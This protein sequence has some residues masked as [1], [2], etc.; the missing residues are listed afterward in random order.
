[1]CETKIDQKTLDKLNI[2][3]YLPDY[4]GYFEWCKPPHKGYSG[5]GILTKVEPLTISYGITNYGK[6]KHRIFLMALWKYF[7]MQIHV[8][9]FLHVVCPIDGFKITNLMHDAEGR[10]ITL[11]FDT[12]YLVSVYVPNSQELLRRLEYRI[13]EWDIDFRRYWKSLLKTGKNVLIVGDMNVAHYPIDL[14]CPRQSEWMAGFSYYE[15][16]SFTQLLREGF[17]DSFRELH[18]DKVQYTWWSNRSKRMRSWNLGWRLDYA[19]PDD[20]LMLAVEDSE[21]HDFARISDHCPVM[22]KLD[23]KRMYDVYNAQKLNQK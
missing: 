17:N 22:I 10:V 2:S 9:Q 1:M 15:R 5:V 19:I 12:F 8:L 7:L 11:E 3:Q 21:I 13:F 18:T 16:S 14:H 23:V 6:R 4:Q 20:N